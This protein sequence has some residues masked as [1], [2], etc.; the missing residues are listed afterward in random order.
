MLFGKF[1]FGGENKRIKSDSRFGFTLIELLIVIGIVAILSTVV[2]LVLN[3][4]EVRKKGR[5]AQRLA[6]ARVLNVGVSLF[7]VEKSSQALGDPIKIYLSLPDNNPDCSSYVLPALPLGWFYACAS[8]TNFQ[9]VD[10][11]GWVPINFSSL[12]SSPFSRLP[13]DPINK[14]EDELYYSYVYNIAKNRWEI[15]ANM[16][17]AA[18]KSG[19]NND[20]ES[21]DGGT[22]VS[23]YEFG[24]DL[25]LSPVDDRSGGSGGAADITPPDAILDLTTGNPSPNSIFV[26]WTAP[27]DDADLG[28]A[29]SYDLR[30]STSPINDSN[31]NLTNQVLGE[32][33]P[34]VAGTLQTI[35]VS[36]LNEST[37]YYFAIKTV[38]EVPNTSIISNIPSL[39]TTQSTQENIVQIPESCRNSDYGGGNAQEFYNKWTIPGS[40]TVLLT[41]F[42]FWQTNATLG[43]TEAVE[44]AIYNG[45]SPYN[46]LSEIVTIYGSGSA[47]WVWGSL[48]TPIVINL[49]Q[50]Y[51]FGI[52][53]KIGTY[54]IAVDD[55]A[56][57]Q[58]YP[59]TSSGN[60]SIY[61]AVA[62]GL[63]VNAPISPVH[64]TMRFGIFGI[65]YY[66]VDQGD[67]TSPI[68]SAV[69]VSN[70]T[71]DSAVITWNTN[72]IAD[73]LVDYGTTIGYGSN[74]SN[75]SYVTG[76]SIN[77]IGL[78]RDT[79][80]HYR[81]KSKDL[82]NN[83]GTSIDFT[84]TT[85]N[86]GPDIE[87]PNV[88]I[89]NPATGAS[90]NGIVAI[91]G[92]AS[93]NRG[94]TKVEV[95]VDS[96]VYSMAA[97]T[98]N[99]SY[100]LNTQT[101]LDGAHTITA[102][103]TDTSG[104]IQTDIINVTVNNT[105]ITLNQTSVTSPI[106]LD[107]ANATYVLANNLTC[108]GSCFVVTANDITF[109][110]NGRVATFGTDAGLYRYGVAI[111][112][113]YTPNPLIFDP[114]DI[115]STYFRGADRTIIKNGSLIQG[116]A[117]TENM[118]IFAHEGARMSEV[119]NITG[120]YQGT[121][122]QG[123]IQLNGTNINI[124]DNI[125]QADLA[126][127][128]NRM[129]A[130]AAISVTVG[131]S[132]VNSVYVRNNTVYGNGQFGINVSS[133]KSQ[134]VQGLEISG[135]IMRI[136]GIT[137]NS[138]QLIVH[139]FSKKQQ[140]ITPLI[141]NNRIESLGNVYNR[142]IILEG[143]DSS[144]E[145]IDGAKIYDNIID[146]KDH[147]YATQYA[148]DQTTVSHGLRMRDPDYMIPETKFFNNEFYGNTFKTTSYYNGPNFTEQ[149][150]GISIRITLKNQIPAG[151]QP[152]IFHD[153]T[154]INQVL[155]SN[156]YGIAIGFE[157]HPTP[158][159]TIFRNNTIISDNHLI[160]SQWSGGSGIQFE[161]NNFQKGTNPT[162]F[163]PLEY[164]N[165]GDAT[166]VVFLDSVFGSG[167]DFTDVLQSWMGSP[168]AEPRGDRSFYVKWTLD[169]TVRNSS[170]QIVSGAQVEI[171]DKD[172]NVVFTGSTDVNG[173]VITPLSEYY[174]RQAPTDPAPPP[175][176]T[177]YNPYTMTATFGG[178]SAV[179][180]V[181]MDAVKAITLTL[182]P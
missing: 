41:K 167:V 73:S 30:Y 111:P 67:T 72:E 123:I 19:G 3:P 122:S 93:D 17:S 92:T 59:P 169:V 133:K 137:A 52:G 109:D 127:I 156:N 32:P 119:A 23:L 155:S 48:S 165:F 129:Q 40:G 37:L 120:Y 15:N 1:F 147:G 91:S 21:N 36:G 80:Y 46:K 51:I 160:K 125:I 60:G 82:N 136:N 12:S 146:I 27:G 35:A 170:G 138:Y 99:W 151:E 83:L 161:A 38:D 42:R 53:P 7:A 39:S 163:K 102:R 44:M 77:L 98:T 106:V 113:D 108:T 110:L 182:S 24:S 100:S 25:A 158:V 86:L 79:L 62:G 34:A 63:N 104:N 112:P 74:V 126:L 10:G 148:V 171:K 174:W 105:I 71:D 159:G 143:I 115:P 75:G 142:G 20:T 29:T 88:A 173:K 5:D 13:T 149:G 128:T 8:P 56:D 54:N 139:G 176:T 116:A 177:Q 179:S 152:N 134:N 130:K 180:V 95:R 135:N 14:A 118:V 64:P 76:H 96:G 107:Q 150:N 157:G 141:F 172:N 117:G 45:S 153:N 81:I 66:A 65:A 22:S 101:L 164:A 178:S 132:T 78:S 2:V 70:I 6:E 49:G 131:S 154:I 94:L 85:T 9:K 166:D 4:S 140:G 26:S 57:C 181:T 61:V 69:S 28:T 124:H 33:T 84:F 89:V 55:N 43:P 114:A 175:V 121:D 18:Y 87:N 145:G 168:P 31:W 47:G 11:A 90:L 162:N 58:E 103:A 50:T 97:G 144:A 68:I 16:E